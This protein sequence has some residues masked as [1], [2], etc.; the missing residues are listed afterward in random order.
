MYNMYLCKHFELDNVCRIV[1]RESL[2]ENLILIRSKGWRICAATTPP[3]TPLTRCSYRTPSSTDEALGKRVFRD[4]SS[5]RFSAILTIQKG[6]K[7]PMV[8]LQWSFWAWRFLH[9]PADQSWNCLL[10][11]HCDDDDDEDDE[12]RSRWSYR[13][14]PKPVT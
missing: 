7:V 6:G 9:R 1:G 10:L 11:A 12:T 2:P 13:G 4:A 8:G 5:C 3:A 14:F